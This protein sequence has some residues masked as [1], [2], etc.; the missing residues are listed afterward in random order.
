M[1]GKFSLLDYGSY[2]IVNSSQEV[3]ALDKYCIMT[4]WGFIPVGI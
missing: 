4:D 1:S 2:L 3:I